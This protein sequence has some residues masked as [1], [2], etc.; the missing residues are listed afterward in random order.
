MGRRHQRIHSNLVVDL[1]LNSGAQKIARTRDIS[2]EGCFINT[3]ASMSVGD[4]VNLTFPIGDA[5]I[6][7]AGTVTRVLPP[8][9]QGGDQGFGIRL[10]SPP[11]L[12]G[13]HVDDVIRNEGKQSAHQYSV[14]IISDAELR[15]QTVANFATANWRVDFAFD[16]ESAKSILG[17]QTF[18][19]VILETNQYERRWERTLALAV[20]LQPTATR[21]VRAKLTG[22]QESTAAAKALVQH[23]TSS[24]S[25]HAQ[26]EKLFRA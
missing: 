5:M 10:H 25:D 7:I 20:S 2:K 15:A 14:L 16:F 1:G 19:A 22:D 12:W 3:N 23:F 18:D 6:A 26:L 24:E 9:A 21:I 11:G 13:Q 4:V 8:S 17:H